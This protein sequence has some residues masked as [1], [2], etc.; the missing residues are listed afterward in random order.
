LPELAKKSFKFTQAPAI[1]SKVQS[2]PTSITTVLAIAASVTTVAASAA[3]SHRAENTRDSSVEASCYIGAKATDPLRGGADKTL[4]RIRN[5][6]DPLVA[7]V[8]DRIYNAKRISENTIV[9]AAALAS[10]TTSVCHLF[11]Q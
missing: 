5:T 6:A 4:A 9:V 1:F 7:G 10:I 2:L 3:A 8:D 11:L